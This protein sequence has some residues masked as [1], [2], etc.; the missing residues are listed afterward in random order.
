[1]ETDPN[2]LAIQIRHMGMDPITRLA[3]AIERIKELHSN[4][5][6]DAS[7]LDAELNGPLL[8]IEGIIDRCAKR[9]E[10]GTRLEFKLVTPGVTLIQEFLNERGKKP[11]PKPTVDSKVT[12]RWSGLLGRSGIDKP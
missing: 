5:P 10:G 8:A 11:N 1:M 4:R 3:E 6:V 9:R 2:N 12:K 7:I